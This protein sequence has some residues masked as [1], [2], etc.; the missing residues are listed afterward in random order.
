MNVTNITTENDV[1]YDKFLIETVVKTKD[2]ART[3]NEK[4]LHKSSW[5]SKI[6]STGISKL[7]NNIQSSEDTSPLSYSSAPS[8][9]NSSEASKVI[10]EIDKND[11]I[12]NIGNI[13]NN[14]KVDNISNLFMAESDAKY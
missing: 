10:N 1:K 14:L 8:I 11:L 7:E 6:L 12:K 3:V 4:S 9:S 2:T 5:E 13:F